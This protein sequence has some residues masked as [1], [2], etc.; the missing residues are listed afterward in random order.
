MPDGDLQD[1]LVGPVIDRQQ[2]VDVGNFHVTEDAG[3]GDIQELF[4]VSL[5]LFVWQETVLCSR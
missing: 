5:F 2:H 3:S 4:V 1:F